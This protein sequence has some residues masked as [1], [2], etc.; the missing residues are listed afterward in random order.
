MVN[1]VAV[2]MKNGTDLVGILLR[3]ETEFLL[4]ENPVEIK[5]DPVHGFY[6]KSWLLLNTT[7]TANISKTDI[8][9]FDEA[10][11]KAI[12]Y[13]EDFMFKIQSNREEVATD[14]DFTSEL[15]EM[16][17]AMLESKVNKIH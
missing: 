7:K 16:F 14:E 4:V 13:Y 10:N 12:S 2:K 17:N 6:A 11:E 3:N 9:L 8:V 1:F 15:E 5:V